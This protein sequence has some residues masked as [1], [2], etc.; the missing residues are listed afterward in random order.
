MIEGGSVMVRNSSIIRVLFV[1]CMIL[2][3]CNNLSAQESDVT[4]YIIGP[5]DILDISVWK[6][7]A[8][9]KLVPVLPDGNIS[10]PLVGEVRAG[11]KTVSQFQ[12][13]LEEQ[14]VRF[15]P[16]PAL[17]VIVQRVNSMQIYVIG[18]VNQ[19]GT[20]GL[21]GNVNVLQA[22]TMAGGLNPFA[23][24]NEIRILRKTGKNTSVLQFNYDDVSVGQKL[25]QNIALVRGEVIVVP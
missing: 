2:F 5:G 12:K 9:T 1:V 20:F 6:N 13:D 11:G 17:S 25:E 23:K 24:R 22:L 18:K 4:K 3:P 15:I 21:N 7:D 10:F 14:L 16:Q 8:L 19:P